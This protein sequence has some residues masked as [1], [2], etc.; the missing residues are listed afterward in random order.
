MTR[1]FNSHGSTQSQKLHF[2]EEISE[3]DR[4][5]RPNQYMSEGWGGAITRKMHIVKHLCRLIVGKVSF[6]Y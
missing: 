3:V 6:T 1:L 4:R 2:P 5:A